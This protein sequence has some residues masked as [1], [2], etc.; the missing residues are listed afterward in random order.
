M[1]FRLICLSFIFLFSCKK[2][3]EAE[4]LAKPKQQNEVKWA[5]AKPA[6]KVKYTKPN[7][8]IHKSPVILK[9]TLPGLENGNDKVPCDINFSWNEYEGDLNCSINH[10]VDL[11]CTGHS[12]VTQKQGDK[13]V[14]IQTGAGIIFSCG[15]TR[16]DKVKFW[17]K[18]TQT[19]FE[20]MFGSFGT[21]MSA[22]LTVDFNS[23]SPLIDR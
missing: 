12:A 20:F 22:R 4:T 23:F 15:E 9:R 13:N 1:D 8:W 10:N 18:A 19:G 5:S 17:N 11:I 7:S 3:T 6:F 21:D 14:E 2:Q 16:E